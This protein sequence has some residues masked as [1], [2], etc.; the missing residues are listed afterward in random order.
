MD[1]VAEY[2]ASTEQGQEFLT[3]LLSIDKLEDA[4]PSVISK[5]ILF[6][7]RKQCRECGKKIERRRRLRC[8]ACKVAAYCGRLCQFS[9]WQNH[10]HVCSLEEETLKIM[11]QGANMASLKANCCCGYLPEISVQPY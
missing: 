8:S 6:L 4:N 7:K 3:Y 11:Q 9:D 10:K 1:R 2:V 5:Y